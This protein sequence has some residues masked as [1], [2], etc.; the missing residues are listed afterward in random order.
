MNSTNS[1]ALGGCLAFLLTGVGCV[2]CLAIIVPDA[3]EDTEQT[4]QIEYPTRKLDFKTLERKDYSIGNRSRWSIDVTASS[5][6]L[7]SH[8]RVWIV[9]NAAVREHR[10]NW[11][12]VVDASL[13]ESRDGDV[14]SIAKITYAP[15]GCGWVGENCNQNLWTGVMVEL[16]PS[17]LINGERFNVPMKA[18]DLPPN[19]HKWGM[20]SERQIDAA[21]DKKCRQNVNCWGR[22]HIVEATVLCQKLVENRSLY[23]YEWTDGWI[24]GKL[25]N[26]VWE[27]KVDGTIRYWGDNVRFQ[28]GFGAWQQMTYFCVY[29][30]VLKSARLTEI[31]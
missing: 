25:E 10:R 13:Y 23:I 31:R 2:A 20:P 17:K 22:K 11:P 4:E 24:G 6:D 21:A 16:D 15:D 26:W 9:M 27:N 3:K 5:V 29:N 14:V 30:P 1:S 19:W 8:E 7:S 28:N 18:I 12:D